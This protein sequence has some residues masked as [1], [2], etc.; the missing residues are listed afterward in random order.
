[1]KSS[2]KS[3]DHKKKQPLTEGR[4]TVGDDVIGALVGTDVIA[5]VGD[6]VNGAEVE[7]D[8]NS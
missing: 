8:W 7:V 1:M 2:F 4:R 3:F 5:E 6:D